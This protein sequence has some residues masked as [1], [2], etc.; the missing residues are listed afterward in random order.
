[1]MIFLAGP[2]AL[3]GRKQSLYQFLMILRAYAYLLREQGSQSRTAKSAVSFCPS[4]F[5]VRHSTMNDV[6]DHVPIAK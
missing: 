2:A 5:H 1:M 6:I 4:K 3:Q